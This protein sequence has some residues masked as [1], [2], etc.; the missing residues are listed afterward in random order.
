MI[1]HVTPNSQEVVTNDVFPIFL[2]E[3]LSGGEHRTLDFCGTGFR[4]TGDVLV[5]CWHCVAA[6]E[7]EEGGYAIAVYLQ[8]REF[9]Y[10][11]LLD[12]ARDE[13]GS[14]LATPRIVSEAETTLPPPQLTLARPG[15]PIG[16]DVWTYGY[17]FTGVLPEEANKPRFVLNGRRL[18]GYITREFWYDHPRLGKISSFELDMPAPEG[19]S[20]A[21]VVGRGGSTVVGVIYGRHDVA[22]V[23]EFSQV[24]PDTGAKT[25]EVQRIVSFGLACDTNTLAALR[26][27]ATG[28]LTLAE[29]QFPL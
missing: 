19:V 10:H 25:P 8:S 5:T 22:V 29:H 13:N 24:D 14:D 6:D 4:L 3:V 21:P 28:G 17:P 27:P 1:R 2:V 16:V 9:R 23:D 7:P 18:Q 20:G 11:P 12:V 26:G 15:A